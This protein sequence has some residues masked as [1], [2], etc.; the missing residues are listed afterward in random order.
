M[1]PRYGSLAFGH[2]FVVAFLRVLV[3]YMHLLLYFILTMCYN[4]EVLRVIIATTNMFYS[5]SIIVWINIGQ[6]DVSFNRCITRNTGLLVIHVLEQLIANTKHIIVHDRLV[7]RNF[8]YRSILDSVRPQMT[9]RSHLTQL[10]WYYL[11]TLVYSTC[12]CQ[13]T[14][15]EPLIISHVQT[16]VCCR[17]HCCVLAS[18]MQLTQ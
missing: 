13:P 15:E 14:W 9:S 4:K 8:I 6:Q 12:N 18:F 5:Y 11:L 16:I 10:C 17:Y 2:L 3:V 7:T 1:I